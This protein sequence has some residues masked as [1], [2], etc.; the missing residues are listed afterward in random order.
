VY[1]ASPDADVPPFVSSGSF[2]SLHPANRADNSTQ[3]RTIAKI[4][5]IIGLFLLF[6]F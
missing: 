4:L 5:F 2:V 6:Y 3:E 1:V